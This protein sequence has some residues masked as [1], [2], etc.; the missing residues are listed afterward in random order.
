MISRSQEKK[1]GHGDRPEQFSVNLAMPHPFGKKE[2]A[3]T[4]KS[5]DHVDLWRSG[6]DIEK[7]GCKKDRR[8]NLVYRP[9]QN[10]EAE[11]PVGAITDPPHFCAA[12]TTVSS[13]FLHWSPQGI[14][15]NQPPSGNF[16]WRQRAFLIWNWKL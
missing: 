14:N 8:P 15:T 16:G 2:Q 7:V 10:G 12:F 3:T 13:F 9:D 4:E 5:N 6:D 1:L 11:N